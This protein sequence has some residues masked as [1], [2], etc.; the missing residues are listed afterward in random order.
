MWHETRSK[1]CKPAHQ[2]HPWQNQPSKGR[3]GHLRIKTNTNELLRHAENWN[4]I[5]VHEYALTM[6]R[7]LQHHSTCI[8]IQ[9]CHQLN[10]GF[11]YRSENWSHH[12]ISHHYII[13][14]T[15]QLLHRL[16]NDETESKFAEKHYLPPSR[17]PQTWNPKWH[18]F[19]GRI[20]PPG[21]GS[22]TMSSC[23][24]CIISGHLSETPAR[25]RGSV[26]S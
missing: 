1:Q 7:F 17:I 8:G 14:A 9:I 20:F 2:H 16:C 4:C 5:L 6:I 15:P 25:Y 13:S 10:C 11:I 12:C 19:S 26:L 23:T 21:E 22:L 3:T 24:S 18:G